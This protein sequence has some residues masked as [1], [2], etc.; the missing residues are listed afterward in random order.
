[1]ASGTRETLGGTG[2]FRIANVA[3]QWT[4]VRPDGGEFLCL[5]LNHVDESDLRYEHNIDIWKN[6][7]GSRKE[8]MRKG[9]FLDLKDWGFN[10]LGWTQQF[11][12]GEFG[13]AGNTDFDWFGT[14][15]NHGHSPG[16]SSTE[17]TSF[18]M[19]YVA[20]LSVA[21]IEDWRGS[22]TFPD[23]FSYDFD[24][25]CA[26]LA[27]SI[28]TE[29]AESRDLLGY[30]FVDIPAWVPHA[31][32]RFFP[33]MEGLTG[34]RYDNR[35]N[36]IAT[37]YYKTVAG[38][39]RKHDKNHLIFGDR[40]NG[41]K[42][43]PEPVLD[44]MSKYVDAIPIQY[45][46]GP[47]NENREEMIA[48]YAKANRITQKPLM[49][50]DIGNWTATTKN[51]ERASGLASQADRGRNYAASLEVLT[52]QSWFIGWQWCGYIENLARG[53]GIKDPWDN[54]YEDF[55]QYIRGSNHDAVVRHA[56]KFNSKGVK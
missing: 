56:K 18:G 33:G 19:P 36:E 52:E 55:V 1:M 46:C 31:S 11:V 54:P 50:V 51:P 6:R 20:N 27:R 43:F 47:T 4:F 21:Q 45:F 16:W 3:D 30:F 2:Y 29:H 10:T 53:W 24:D 44:A 49:N 37:Q 9:P 17:L 22:P 13:D 26:Y 7:Y 15:F 8:W 42:G 14:V 5:G 34:D 38:H 23:V 25:W 35:L 40:F 48:V 12:S 32:G 28:C 39:I 41:N